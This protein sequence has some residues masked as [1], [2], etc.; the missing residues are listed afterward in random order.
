MNQETGSHLLR[1]KIFVTF[2]L[3]GFS[4]NIQHVKDATDSYLTVIVI[5]KCHFKELE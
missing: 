1:V 2:I 4:K 5:L 3:S